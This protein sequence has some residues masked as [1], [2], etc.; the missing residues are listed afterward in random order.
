ML[1][2]ARSVIAD[3][4]LYAAFSIPGA[5]M[6]GVES[7]NN[8]GF[9][10][11]WYVDLAGN[12]KAF[13]RSPGRVLTTFTAPGDTG[14]PGFTR[15]YQVNSLGTVAGEYLDAVSGTYSGFLYDSTTQTYTTYN[16]PGQPAGT[17]TAILGIGETSEQFC[18]FV[19]SPPYTSTSAFVSTDGQVQIFNV[20]G[21]VQTI[22]S[23]M[24]KYGA[25]V[26]SYIDASGVSHGYIRTRTGQ[27]TVIDVPGASQSASGLPC[28]GVGGG[29]ALV[30]ISD[31]FDTAGYFWDTANNEHGFS[32]TPGGIVNT[33]D[34]PGAFQTAGAGPNNPGTVVGQY[35]DTSCKATAFIARRKPGGH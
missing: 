24:N 1:V 12:S 20:G 19:S 15:A 11:G 30:G 8:T 26:G 32:R 23:A 10:S 14:R 16:V 3:P 13:L 9:I 21:S 7:I 5:A 27:I 18:G 17:R 25:S 22:C 29:T 33:V 34:Y 2:S 31:R 4:F 35:Q 6:L 28:G